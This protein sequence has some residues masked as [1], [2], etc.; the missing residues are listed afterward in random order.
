VQLAGVPVP[1]TV[2]GLL[3]STG[4]ASLGR[5]SVV[6]PPS[7][8]PAGGRD[9]GPASAIVE[10][11]ELVPPALVVPLLLLRLPE[12]LDDDPAAVVAL[13][14]VAPEPLPAGVFAEQ[15]AVASSAASARRLR[16]I[17]PRVRR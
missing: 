12:E 13:P 8:L 11:L 5:G 15:A 1:T 4:C 17:R 7:G 9:C 3:V 2:V 6:Q 14:E 10:P 16:A